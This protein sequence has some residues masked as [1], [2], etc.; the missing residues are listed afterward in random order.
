M[1]RGFALLAACA[2]GILAQ[3]GGAAAVIERAPGDT[4]QTLAERVIPKDHELSHPPVELQFGPPGKHIVIFHAPKDET[5]FMGTI[6]LDTKQGLKRYD[7]S[8]PPKEIPGQFEYEIQAVLAENADAGIGRELIVLYAYH[9]NGSTADDG[10]A[11]LVYRWDGKSFQPDK[12]A[13]SKLAGAKSA[14]EIRTR[15]RTASGGAKSSNSKRIS[16]GS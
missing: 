11:T 2:A 5:N 4:L 1:F 6:L 15:L 12:Q 16:R 14:A 8:G 9:R 10:N 3:D 13:A 7:I